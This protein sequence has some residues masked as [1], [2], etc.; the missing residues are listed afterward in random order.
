MLIVAYRPNVIHR[1]LALRTS[2]VMRAPRDIGK[3]ARPSG[4]CSSNDAA[5]TGK[6]TY[7]V[8]RDMR[9]AL[10]ALARPRDA[11]AIA[12]ANFDTASSWPALM[13]SAHRYIASR[14][15]GNAECLLNRSHR[16]LNERLGQNLFPCKIFDM[17][18]AQLPYQAFCR[19]RTPIA[20]TDAAVES[21]R[22]VPRTQPIGYLH[23][24]TREKNSSARLRHSV[25]G[26][27]RADS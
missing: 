15:S 18:L 16:R 9:L 5:A 14:N 1:C 10:A 22:K 25:N 2:P 21:A 26:W 12:L 6:E 23:R 7:A 17:S 3:S 24:P 13:A 8:K 11:R 27:P 19:V 20:R 4:R